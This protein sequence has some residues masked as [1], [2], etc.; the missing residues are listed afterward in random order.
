MKIVIANVCGAANKGDAALL[1]ALVCFLEDN[2]V[3]QKCME[4]I[5]LCPDMQVLHLPNIVWHERPLT[6]HASSRLIRRFDN[7]WMWLLLLAYYFGAKWALNLLPLGQQ[8]AI[9]ALESSDIVISCPGGYLEDSNL[10]YI[11]NCFQLLLAI[12]AGVKLILAPQSIGPVRSRLGKK[13]IARVV[14][15]A[16]MVYV[17]D[18]DS[19]RCISQVFRGGIPS[20]ILKAGDM[21]FWHV[22]SSARGFD[23]S[24][25]AFVGERSP[26]I[27]LSIIDWNFPGHSDPKGLRIRYLAELARAVEEIYRRG[28]C[29]VCVNQ[30]SWDL[31]IAEELFS[32][33]S[34]GALFVDKADHSASTL[35]STIGALNGFIGSRLHSCIFAL[36]ENTPVIALA[37]LPKTV[38]VF[39]DLGLGSQVRMI[40]CF[41]GLAVVSDLLAMKSNGCFDDKISDYRDRNDLSKFANCLKLA[42]SNQHTS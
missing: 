41:D 33:V 7:A 1:E 31:H 29:V 27:G 25:A 2:G 18:Q 42:L 23:S 13:L 6:S 15:S 30:V 8:N 26:V 5:A 14:R 35:R 16:E 4:G 32:I 11:T 28:G 34:T 40:E 22:N 19:L 39:D 36:L 3:D 21:A 24:V 9:E 10:S 12:K 17:R 20:H 37:Y 38:G